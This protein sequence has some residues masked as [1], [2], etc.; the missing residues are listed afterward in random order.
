MNLTSRTAPFQWDLPTGLVSV[1]AAVLCLVPLAGFL[2]AWHMQTSLPAF[3][4]FAILPAL[5]LMAAGE[6]YLVQRSPLLFNRLV[7]GLM[8]GLAG[9]LAFDAVRFLASFG[10]NAPDLTPVIG[11]HLTG[12][13][14][15]VMPSTAATAIGYGYGYLLIG[16]LLGAAYSLTMGKGRW[17]WAAGCGLLGALA[18]VALPQ[19]QLFSVAEGYNLG[20][21][22]AIYGVAIVVGAAVTGAVVQRLGRTRANAFY[23]VFLREDQIEA[24]ELALTR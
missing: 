10:H 6:W 24:P 11:Q 17:Y 15:G 20:T 5:V 21:A 1:V 14:V 12:E 2:L 22:A 4:R 16:A 19:F 8:G 13:L 18:F 7:S 3:T 9:A 23:V